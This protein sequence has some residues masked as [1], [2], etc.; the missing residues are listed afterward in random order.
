MCEIWSHPATSQH[1]P[2]EAQHTGTHIDTQNDDSYTIEDWQT[3]TGNILNIQGLDRK[4]HSL[5]T[6]QYYCY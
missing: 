1:L 2:A 4:Y 3:S 5:G 6:E